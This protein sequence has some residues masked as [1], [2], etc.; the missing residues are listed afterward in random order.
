MFSH[1]FPAILT[2]VMTGLCIW[3][4]IILHPCSEVS[5]WIGCHVGYFGTEFS[6]V[7]DCFLSALRKR[8]KR[9]RTAF[10]TACV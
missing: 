7:N 1:H 4:I 9:H 6:F 5:P 10:T 3:I 8:G 2:V